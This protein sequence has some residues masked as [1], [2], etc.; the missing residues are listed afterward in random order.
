VAGGRRARPAIAASSKPPVQKLIANILG[1]QRMRF[2]RASSGSWRRDSPTRAAC[3]TT[4]VCR[5]RHDPPDQAA[6]STVLRVHEI[7]GEPIEQ[8]RMGRFVASVPMDGRSAHSGDKPTHPELL[9]WLSDDF[10]NTPALV[11]E[12]PDPA[13]RD[14]AT[15]KQSSRTRPEL[16]VATPR[17][18]GRA[19][20]PHPAPAEM[21]PISFRHG[22][23]LDAAIG[24]PSAPTA[25]HKRGLY[26]KFKALDPGSDADDLRRPG[27]PRSVARP[28]NGRTRRSR[29]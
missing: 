17:T 1:R 4:A 7:V 20:K 9:D 18:A 19:G 23:L 5:R 11:D 8:F 28:A 3:A 2:V 26:V 24:G 25:S 15:Y 10:V 12:G 21:S 13:D 14:V 16:R 22:G 6:S 29:R 27:W